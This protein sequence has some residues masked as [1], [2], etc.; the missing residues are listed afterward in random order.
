MNG[1]PSRVTTILRMSGEIAAI[2]GRRAERTAACS[3]GADRLKP[4]IVR[5]KRD[6]NQRRGHLT[7]CKV[8]LHR[9]TLPCKKMRKP[10]RIAV[11]VFPSSGLFGVNAH[12]R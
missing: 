10:K 11:N 2:C 5:S 1:C 12:C 6:S 4:N 8:A 9:L 7:V 3:D